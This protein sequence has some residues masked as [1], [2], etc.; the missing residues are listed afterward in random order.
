[1]ANSGRITRAQA[2]RVLQLGLDRILEDIKDVYKG[3]GDKIFTSINTKKAYYEAMKMAGAGIAAVKGEGE[4]ITYDS[5]DQAWVYTLPIVTYEKSARITMEAKEDNLY[6]D[7]LNK[8]GRELMKAIDVSRDTIEANIFNDAF[9][10]GVTYGD[11]AVLCATSHTLQAGGTNSNR[12]ASDSDLSEETLENMK[13]LA[14]AM[15]NDDGILGDYDTKALIVHPSNQFE[16]WRIIKSMGRV[17]T[18]DN[19]TNALREMGIVKQLVVWRR[20]SDSDAFFVTTDCEDG[21]VLARR[22]NVTTSSFNDPYTYDTILTAHERYA[23]GV[24][25]HQSVL[26]TP[27]A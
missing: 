27:G 12:L 10:S 1:M 16:A 8:I 3:E 18:P 5:R 4:A 14:D 9:T 22:K 24:N 19:D 6:E 21:L 13:I 23:V 26:G 17:S 20:L 25:K 11:G 2:P 7:Q 15:K